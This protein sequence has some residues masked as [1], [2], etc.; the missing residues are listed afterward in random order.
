MRKVRPHLLLIKPRLPRTEANCETEALRFLWSW[1]RAS[2][3]LAAQQGDTPQR[4]GH[5]ATNK[6]AR[7]HGIAIV[8]KEAP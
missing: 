6:V 8:P 3:R 7:R 5:L 1:T 2:D 4:N